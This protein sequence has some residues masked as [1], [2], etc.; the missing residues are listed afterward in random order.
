[1]APGESLFS[2]F[3]SHVQRKNVR[4]LHH[5]ICY[6][7]D[8]MCLVQVILEDLEHQGP[9]K[10]YSCGAAT[11][12]VPPVVFIPGLSTTAESYHKQVTAL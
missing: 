9:W 3:R 5:K 11:N 7:N 12:D 10:T 1:M 6:K 8:L 2:R 4:S